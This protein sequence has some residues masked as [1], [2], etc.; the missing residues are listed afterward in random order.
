MASRVQVGTVPDT[1]AASGRGPRLAG[2]SLQLP[3]LSHLA[4]VLL[5]SDLD[6]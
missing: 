6:P 3:P 1:E 4:K 5:I 2:C